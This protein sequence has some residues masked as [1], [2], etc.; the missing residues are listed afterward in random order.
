MPLPDFEQFYDKYSDTLYRSVYFKVNSRDQTSD[1]VQE[2]FVRL[3]RNWHSYESETHRIRSL[4]TIA[5]NLTTDYFRTKHRTIPLGDY[6]VMDTTDRADDT[7]D[8]SIEQDRLARALS[9]LSDIDRDIVVGHSID[10]QS[11]RDLSRIHNKPE[12]TIRK[13]HS[14]AL[15]KLT[16]AFQTLYGINYQ[17][18]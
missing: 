13:I 7:T 12:A 14:R 11:Y 1:I 6:D 15:Q 8:T 2:S 5:R 16:K 3:W 9:Q 17:P 10:E 18:Y 4:Y